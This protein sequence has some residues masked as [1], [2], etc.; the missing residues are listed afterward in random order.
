MREA[1]IQ[2][3]VGMFRELF[4]GDSSGTTYIV[5]H[6]PR[7]GMLGMLEAVDAAK[8]SHRLGSAQ[9]IA[10][11]TNHVME[12]LAAGNR[13]AETGEFSLDWEGTWRVQEVDE[14]AWDSLRAALKHEYETALAVFQSGQ[15]LSEE[16]YVGG[17]AMIGHT[18]YHVGAIRQLVAAGEE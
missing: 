3:F 18:A 5:E 16:T 4:E 1:V 6:G 15:K 12:A 13:W 11:H 9:S 2:G 8:A 7:G 17:L 14:P 10:A